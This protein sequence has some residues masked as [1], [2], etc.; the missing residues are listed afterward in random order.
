M[1]CVL[2]NE[3]HN[4]D[5]QKCS[6]CQDDILEDE[7]KAVRQ[8]FFYMAIGLG[9]LLICALYIAYTNGFAAIENA[10]LLN[11]CLNCGGMVNGQCIY[12]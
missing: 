5:N 10:E 2:C 7:I 3:E 4:P 12:K 11:K 1:K 9:V 8:T 6:K